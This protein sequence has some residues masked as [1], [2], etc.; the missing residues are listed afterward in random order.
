MHEMKE[1][2]VWSLGQEDPLEE[3]MA[4]HSSILAWRIPMDRRAWQVTVHIAL[5]RVGLSWIDLACTHNKVD[6][7]KDRTGTW[8]E[9]WPALRLK[10]TASLSNAFFPPAAYRYPCLPI[11]FFS[12][13]KC[14]AQISM[15]ILTFV[16]LYSFSVGSI[17]S[18]Y[19][20]LVRKSL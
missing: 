7:A 3:C 6:S 19:W 9:C 13:K 2:W 14:R 1:T 12:K 10:H 5:Q 15:F 11:I 18:T 4:T 20:G 17:Y 16:I 8:W